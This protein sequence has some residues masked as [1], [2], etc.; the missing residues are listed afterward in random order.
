MLKGM[1]GMFSGNTQGQ[2]EL[3]PVDHDA[4]VNDI[5]EL[6]ARRFVVIL[7]SGQSQLL[8]PILHG[9]IAWNPTAFPF[10]HL[11]E[12]FQDLDDG[13]EAAVGADVNQHAKPDNQKR[14]SMSGNMLDNNLI[15][16]SVTVTVFTSFFKVP[17]SLL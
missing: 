3:L 2:E 12:D 1:A 4:L 15:C 10:K 8:H 13:A 7:V 17:F 9:I 14:V 5:R 6:L 16:S 11:V